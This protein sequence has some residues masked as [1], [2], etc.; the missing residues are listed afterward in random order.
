MYSAEHRTE[1]RGAHAREDY[2]ERDDEHWLK[3]TLA[4][5]D[6]RGQVHFDY[7]PVHLYTLT[8]EV[9]PVPPKARTY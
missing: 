5:V 4:A 2:K 6:E 8:D 9:E 3:H 7:R 1:S